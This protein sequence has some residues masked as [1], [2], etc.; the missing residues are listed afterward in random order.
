MDK[1]HEMIP[2]GP[3]FKMGE[4]IKFKKNPSRKII[5]M[6]STYYQVD[7]NNTCEK[8]SKKECRLAAYDIEAADREA[9]LSECP[10]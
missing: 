4:C 9:I 1:V 6:F 3:K 8:G 10:K 2:L 5:Q 7:I